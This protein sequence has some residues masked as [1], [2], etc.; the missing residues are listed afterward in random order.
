MHPEFEHALFN[1]IWGLITRALNREDV[2]STHL[3]EVNALEAEMAGHV[4]SYRLAR[5]WLV[6][7]PGAPTEF[8]SF[9]EAAVGLHR[10]VG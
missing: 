8:P 3:D 5:G 7:A 1:D 4:L 10:R 6:R 2:E 9:S